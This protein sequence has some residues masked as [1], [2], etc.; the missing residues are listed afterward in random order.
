MVVKPL[1][2]LVVYSSN[3]DNYVA[4]VKDVGIPGAF[5]TYSL[6]LMIQYAAI[7]GSKE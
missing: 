1:P 6:A 7:L 2:V 4:C 5:D 3:V